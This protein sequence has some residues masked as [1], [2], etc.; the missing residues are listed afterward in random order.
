MDGEVVDIADEAS[1]SICG[2]VE[3]VG[4]RMTSSSEA[5]GIPWYLHVDRSPAR[6]LG[7]AP[8]VATLYQAKRD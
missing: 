4:E 8:T 5:L 7:F 3:L 6:S 2:L 1:T